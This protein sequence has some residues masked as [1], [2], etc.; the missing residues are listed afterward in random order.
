MKRHLVSLLVAGMASLAAATAHSAVLLYDDFEGAPTPANVPGYATVTDFSSAVDWAVGPTVGS[1]DGNVDV[2]NGSAGSNFSGFCGAGGG[3][4]IDLDGTGSANS[5][6]L[7]TED[8][9]S[10]QA[11]VTYELTAEFMGNGRID[12]SD[13]FHF[14][15]SDSGSLGGSFSAGSQPSLQ[16]GVGRTVG[17]TSISLFFTPLA[18]TIS[19][20]FFR[21]NSTADDYGIRL[22]SVELTDNTVVPLPAAAWLLLSGLAGVGLIARRR[23]SPAVAA[24]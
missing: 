21:N 1:V 23:R 5:P 6:Y 3:N 20:L 18:D 8:T 15:F 11:N 19:R 12:S 9:F 16:I 22:L 14:G 4:C 10:L 2:V 24:A 13:N 17:A 7:Y